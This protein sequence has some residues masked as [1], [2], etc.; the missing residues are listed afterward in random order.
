MTPEE[1]LRQ[2]VAHIRVVSQQYLNGDPAPFQACW[3]H[4]DDVTI[5]GAWGAY[6]R[7]WAQ[8]GPRLEWGAERYR[9]GHTDFELLALSASDHLGYTVWIERG[10]AR[11]IGQDELRPT[12]LRVTQ[13]YRREA[14]AWKIT[15]RHGDAITD[16]I[17][18]KAVLQ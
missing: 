7:G 9:G 5:F 17:E 14:G 2:T 1:E 15:H 3:S 8:V 16:K 6:E 4:A 18:A 11:V 12:A 10:E 13:L